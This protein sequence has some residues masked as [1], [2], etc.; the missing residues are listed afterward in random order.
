[1]ILLIR[2]GPQKVQSIFEVSFDLCQF[3]KAN[4]VR[5]SAECAFYYIFNQVGHLNKS[6]G[7]ISNKL[8]LVTDSEL[9]HSQQEVL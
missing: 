3:E 7:E 5:L 1:M 8:T 4:S 9:G 2:V 6:L